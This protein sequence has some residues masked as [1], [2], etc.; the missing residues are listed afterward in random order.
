MMPVLDGW[1]VL[2]R[3]EQDPGLDDLPVV[4]LTAL[5]E[6]RD[7]IRGHLQGAVRYVTKP[8]E[9]RSLLEAVEQALE[10]PTEEERAERRRKV[11]ALLQ[12]LAE[13][14]SGRSAGR[15]VRFSRLEKPPEPEPAAPR[16][17]DVDRTRLNALTDKQRYIAEQ[18]AAGRSARELAEELEVCRSNIYATRKRIGR[19]LGVGADEVAREAR[20]LGLG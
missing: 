14:D 12:R 9:M 7:L 6:E 18:L 16:I 17:S 5:S 19:K 3:L 20:R 10:E 11:R 2:S 13:L 8:F 15:P 1:G 4:M